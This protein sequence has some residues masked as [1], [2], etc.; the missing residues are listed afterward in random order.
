MSLKDAIRTA[1]LGA[2]KNFKSETVKV[3]GQDV[4]VRASTVGERARRLQRYGIGDEKDGSKYLAQS[5]I[6]MCFDEAGNRVFEEADME[7]LIA[8][9]CGG[10]FDDLV[11]AVNRLNNISETAAKNSEATPGV[12]ISS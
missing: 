11:A 2:A 1:T 6:D 9:P 3:Y 12:K 8:Q 10:W 5:I 7:G 4:I